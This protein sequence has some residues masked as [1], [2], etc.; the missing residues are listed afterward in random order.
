[1]IDH[2]KSPTSNDI[3]LALLDL[4]AY[5]KL[6][7]IGTVRFYIFLIIKQFNP[8]KDKKQ[9]IKENTNDLLLINYIKNSFDIIITN[10][11]E[12]KQNLYSEV[13]EN[14][15]QEYEAVLI[16]YEADIREHIKI[17]HQMKLYIDN[18]EAEIEELK[19]KNKL[20]KTRIE[21]LSQ[22]INS[23]KLIEEDPSLLFVGQEETSS[24]QDTK[25]ENENANKNCKFRR[26]EEEILE[27]KNK[28]QK[29]EE[30]NNNLSN[31]I[32]KLKDENAVKINEIRELENKYKKENKSLKKKLLVSESKIK[33]LSELNSYSNYNNK[34]IQLKKTVCTN[35]SNNSIQNIND[36]ESNNSVYKKSS[37][38]KDD[39]NFALNKTTRFRKNK[40]STISATSSIDKIGK[41]LRR[42]Y[43]TLKA[44]KSQRISTI[45]K[46]TKNKK[47]NNSMI[48]TKK[49]DDIMKILLNDS[50]HNNF[51]E[52]IK[53]NRSVQK[54]DENTA[55]Y[56]GYIKKVIIKNDKNNLFKETNSSNTIKKT[57]VNLTKKTKIKNN[58]FEMINNTNNIN[59]L[60][61]NLKQSN[62]NSYY[63][64]N[65]SNSSFNNNYKIDMIKQQYNNNNTS[66]L[67]N[68]KTIK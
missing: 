28:L 10:L 33:Q 31:N 17:E 23:M 27:L 6:D 42:K 20:K 48:T 35:K 7:K 51:T 16:K 18:L 53:V 26:F 1:M 14:K 8:N 12:V 57:K 61:N 22:R 13:R 9:E 55:Y 24:S 30:Q 49:T 50:N 40:A 38:E 32:K 56:N 4:Y 67:N 58:I 62:H 60:Y 36:L 46:L 11:L 2:N 37:K 21:Q 3:H 15:R 52:R 29:Y 47:N 68:K 54:S 66:N 39:I 5:L 41:Y 19:Y 65:N 63:K 64:S 44:H 45:L 25:T 43:S 34:N 59:I